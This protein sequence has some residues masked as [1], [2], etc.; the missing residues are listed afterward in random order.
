MNQAVDL[1]Y[2]DAEILLKGW[3]AF[4]RREVDEEVGLPSCSPAFEGYEAPDWGTT[5]PALSHAD[6]DRCCW[7]MLVIHSRHKKLY[8]DAL[9][10]YRDGRRLGWQ[11]LDEIR[12]RFV[13]VWLEWQQ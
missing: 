1:P 10:H 3:G 13:S 12:A 4:L 6:M 7:A 2:M 11:R 8:R 5:P 9:E